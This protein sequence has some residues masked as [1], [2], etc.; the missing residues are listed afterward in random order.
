V[1]GTRENN[2]ETR[3]V[4]QS[5]KAEK[6]QTSNFK[7]QESIKLQTRTPDRHGLELEV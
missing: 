7:L 3:H 4:K 1:D 6:L 2:R 5:E